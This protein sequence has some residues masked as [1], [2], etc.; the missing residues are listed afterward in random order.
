MNVAEEIDINEGT[1]IVFNNINLVHRVRM[2]KNKI[3]D[4][5]KRYRSFLAFFIVDPEKPIKSTKDI[6][7][8]KRQY[9][10]EF[11]TENTLINSKDIA[12]IICEYES[13]GYTL[14]QAK[15]IRKLDIEI[16]QN[17]NGEWGGR[18]Y[19]NS[20]ERIWFKKGEIDIDDEDYYVVATNSDL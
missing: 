17:E 11:I 6:P 13:C 16:R 1:M 2:L 20:G 15:E 14:E 9:F 4:N 3:N 18:N 5:E 10:I 7:S 19:G 12:K 8:L